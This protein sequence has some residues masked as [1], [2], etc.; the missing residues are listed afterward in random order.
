MGALDGSIAH[1]NRRNKNLLKIKHV[2]KNTVANY[3]SQRI[4][5]AHLMKVDL[6]KGLAMNP[7]FSLSD[8]SINL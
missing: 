8:Y 3:I 1:I 4:K 7:A 6:F 5:G 2:Q